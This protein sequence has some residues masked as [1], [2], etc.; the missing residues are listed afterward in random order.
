[1]SRI[2]ERRRMFFSGG[3]VKNF[4]GQIIDFQYETCYISI[5]KDDDEPR[6]RSV[7][8]K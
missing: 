7:R 4:C 2:P 1:M 8:G 5:L 3:R 6:C